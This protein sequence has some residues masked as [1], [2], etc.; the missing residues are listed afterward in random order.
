MHTVRGETCS[1]A[2]LRCPRPHVCGGR[3]LD[4]VLRRHR[5]A[6]RPSGPAVELSHRAPALAACGPA[7]YQP[8]QQT[9]QSTTSE[10]LAQGL[11][12]K[13]LPRSGLPN[14]LRAA[15][16]HRTLDL[17][18]LTRAI[19][20]L[21]AFWA[22]PALLNPGVAL[23]QADR[24]REEHRRLAE[25]IGARQRERQT[26]QSVMRLLERQ[27]RRLGAARLIDRVSTATVDGQD[28]RG[29]C[30]ACHHATIDRRSASSTDPRRIVEIDRPAG[31]RQ[32]VNP[33]AR[34]RLN[35]AAGC[36]SGWRRGH[37]NHARLIVG[38]DC[39]AMLNDHVALPR[40]LWPHNRQERKCSDAI[41]PDS[42]PPG[43]HFL[44]ACSAR[45]TPAAV[46]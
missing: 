11:Y 37:D 29:A 12:P 10:E 18:S 40:G 3:R 28:R 26:H 8:D 32:P 35:C 33:L 20:V 24:A 45:D 9:A 27:L 6:M 25:L 17:V 34:K 39:R 19:R 1:E 16:R 38:D 15:A 36:A 4:H 31:L 7:P 42:T 14:A 2:A 41:V 30:L 23:P 43:I 5:L 44:T 13:L 22:E 21:T 46:H